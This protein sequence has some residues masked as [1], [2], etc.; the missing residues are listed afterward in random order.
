LKAGIKPTSINATLR[1]LQYF[2]RYL[3]SE[4]KPICERMREVRPLK[5]GQP[6]PRDLSVS[7]VKLLLNAIQNDI[8]RAWIVLMLHSGLRTCE[9]RN[10][11][12]DD[13]YLL[14]RTV[15]IRKTKN[16][17]Q[18]VVYL[19]Q[20]AVE[21]LQAYLLKRDNSN[22]YIFTRHHT[23]LSKRYCQSR[24]RTLGK[25]ISIKVTPHQLRHTCGIFLLNV[26]I[27][28]FALQSLL[29]HRYVETTLNY[30]RLYDET[31]AKQ[32]LETKAP[33]C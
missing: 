11:K 12:I 19:S 30:A 21:A 13:I 3:Q 33:S 1:T 27:S 32:F 15:S 8:Y 7:Q 2:L 5:I 14:Q 16:Q 26:G 10:L 18:R 9:V 28:I 24:L 25:K 22:D 6:L 4:E 31:I 23:Q 29:R 20:P 17:R